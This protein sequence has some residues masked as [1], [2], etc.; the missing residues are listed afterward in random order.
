MSILA[1]PEAAQSPAAAPP[2]RRQ[3]WKRREFLFISIGV[4]LLFGV[5]AGYLVV[6]RYSAARKLTFNAGPKSPNASERA[7][8]HRVQMQEKMKN[9][10]AA[11]PKRVLS[12]GAAKITLPPLPDIAGPKNATPPPLMA[13]AG[14]NAKFGSAPAT[15]GAI[16]GTG[17][18]A[19]INFFGIKDKSNSIVIMIDVSDSMFTRTGDA[20]SGKLL[21]HGKDQNFQTVRDEAIRLVE[22]LAPEIQFGIVRWS[23]GARTWKPELVPATEENKKAAIEH[24]QNEVDMKTAKPQKGQAGGTRHDLAIQAAFGLKPQVIYM[25]TDGNATISQPGGG[26]QPIPPEELYKAAAEGQKNLRTSAKL[27]VIYYVTGDEREDE[28]QMLRNLSARN[29]GS[30]I[31][32]KAKGR[33]G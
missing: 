18:G 29:G 11:I 21:K 24:I 15:M 32:V 13:A 23:G 1:E 12:T 9:A 22:S 26:L 7:I 4:H 16:G 10:P 27:H 6:S 8:Q 19:A 3:W 28:R 2:K 17:S 5:G 33:K 31:S 20:E 14:Q 25:L 30:F